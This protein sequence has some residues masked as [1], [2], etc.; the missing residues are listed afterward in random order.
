MHALAVQFL[1]GEQYQQE[2]DMV[3]MMA[4]CR[5]ATNR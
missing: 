1:E 5:Q 4:C 3:Q 2:I